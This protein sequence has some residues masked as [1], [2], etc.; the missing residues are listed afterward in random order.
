[1]LQLLELA[2]CLV[3]GGRILRQ[4]LEEVEWFERPE[5][6]GQADLLRHPLVA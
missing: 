2:H 5:V 3:L 4:A 6:W 1:M